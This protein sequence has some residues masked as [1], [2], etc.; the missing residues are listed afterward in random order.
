MALVEQQPGATAPGHPSGIAKAESWVVSNPKFVLALLVILVIALVWTYLKGRG[1][2][3]FA[4]TRKDRGKKP[5][6]NPSSGGDKKTA[7]TP[8]DQL[9]ASINE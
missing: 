3:L 7:E 5:Q 8:T 4:S 9:I 1:L 6:V 2:K